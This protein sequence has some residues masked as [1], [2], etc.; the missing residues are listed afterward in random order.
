MIAANLIVDLDGVRARYECY[1][2]GCAQPKEGPAFGVEDVTAFV[3]VIRNDHRARC[4]AD[5]SQCEERR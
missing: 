5:A 3:A 1:R 2:P 4:T